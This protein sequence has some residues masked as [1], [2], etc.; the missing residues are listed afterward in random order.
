MAINIEQKDIIFD[1][2]AREAIL[3]G[4]DILARAVRVTL[5]P[6]GRNVVLEK[7]FGPPIITK[8]GV[9]VAREVQLKDVF[10]NLGAQMVKEVASKTCDVAGDGTTSATVLAHAIYREGL[11]YISAGHNPMALKRGIEKAVAAVVNELKNISKPIENHEEIAQVGRISSNNDQSIGDIIAEAMDRVGK[12]GVITVEESNAVDTTLEV[13]EGMQFDRGFMAPHF[14][15]DPGKMECVLNDPLILIVERKISD[16]KDAVKILEA[17]I[18]S[19]PAPV[20]ILAEDF[21]RIPLSAFVINSIRFRQGAGGVMSCAAKTPAF[22]ERRKAIIEDL[23]VLT[24]AEPIMDALGRRLADINTPEGRKAFGRAKKVVVTRDSTLIIGGAGDQA[25][26]NGRVA[27]I[28]KRLETTTSEY[29]KEKLQE[30]LAKLVG[31]VAVINIGGAT[32]TEVKERAMRFDDALHATRA[33]V[34]EGIVPGGG[35]ALLR[36]RS[37]IVRQREASEGQDEQYGIDIVLRAIEEPARFIAQNGNYEGAV[38]VEKICESENGVGF[39]A[40]TGKFEDLVAAGI[41]DPV[42]VVRVALQN[43]SSIASLLLTTECIIALAPEKDID[44]TVVMPK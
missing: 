30:R 35:V 44:S 10:E 4:V 20:L 3:R 34:E 41:V 12:E 32:E 6:K 19:G 23:G 11:K 26:I 27:E 42:K 43:A 22:G 18:A 36:C 37:S 2:K 28:R 40:E 17:A 38:V 8:D 21:D 15:T 14:V 24:G 5:G 33:A 29:D 13:V 7:K 31:G 9:T 1:Q 39:N 25:Q 16:V